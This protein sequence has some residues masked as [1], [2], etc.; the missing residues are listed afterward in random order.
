[1][2]QKIKLLVAVLFLL[3]AAPVFARQQPDPAKWSDKQVAVWFA[4]SNWYK[5]TGLKPDISINKREF[6]IRYYKNKSLWDKAFAFLLDAD[7][8]ALKPG[9][10][11]L[12]GKDLFVKVTDYQTKSAESIPFESHS[13]YSD[14]HTVVSGMEYI[15]ESVPS[16]ATIKTPYN[17]E[18][19]IAYYTVRKSRNLLGVPGKFF[20][21]FPDNLHRQGVQ[22]NK[23]EN[24]KKIVIK[25]KN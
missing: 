7:L 16:V 11:E 12:Q 24:L 10:Y 23:S 17:E 25:V 19:D 22:V 6:A 3:F 4:K 8:T 18:K 15:G 9:V 13:K 21:L 5:Q 20:L 14:I 1:M 2:K